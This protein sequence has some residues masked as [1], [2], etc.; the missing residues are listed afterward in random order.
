VGKSRSALMQTCRYIREHFHV[1]S[2]PYRAHHEDRFPQ[3]RHAGTLA[4]KGGGGVVHI[5][6]DSVN[7]CLVAVKLVAKSEQWGFAAYRRLLQ[8]IEFQRSARHNNVAPLFEAFQTPE[9]V[10]FSM[11]A[12]EGKSLRHAFESVKRQQGDMEVFAL[13]IVREITKAIQYLFN[14][15]RI[16]HRDIKPDNIVLSG[17]F[18]NVMLIDFGLAE[19]VESDGQMY[20][21]CGTKGFASPEN[22]AAVNRGE[23]KFRAT[24]SEIHEGD[25]FSL[26]VVAFILVSGTRPFRTLGF[27]EMQQQL[28]QGLHCTGSRWDSVAATTKQ[29][30]EWMLHR[31]HD[32]RATPENIL[33]HE[34]MKG[35]DAK[36]EP[37]LEERR[38]RQYEAAQEV[39]NDYDLLLDLSELFAQEQ[40]KPGARA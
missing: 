4:G 5:V 15:N 7:R 3:T 14:E 21:P 40:I 36:L 24:A 37:L 38:R 17:D 26:G 30:I 20:C 32:R 18:G 27:R 22:I 9:T 6:Q 19:R 1:P 25:V 12:G 10:C 28:L 16:V 13:Y 34:S 29:L 31:N 39:H 33:Q 8:E 2:L 11:R 35:L 23:A